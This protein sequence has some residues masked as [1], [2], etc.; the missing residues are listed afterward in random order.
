MNNGVM[1]IFTISLVNYSVSFHMRHNRKPQPQSRLDIQKPHP[2]LWE[3]SGK[4]NNS[5]DCLFFLIRLSM[6]QYNDIN[7]NDFSKVISYIICENLV[8]QSMK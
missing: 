8:I 4:C 6:C 3:K 1:I 7:K 5:A 2:L